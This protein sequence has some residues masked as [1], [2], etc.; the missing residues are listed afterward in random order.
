MVVLVG[1]NRF[2]EQLEGII[3]I[4]KILKV[5]LLTFERKR[6]SVFDV[7]TVIKH[8]ENTLPQLI[9]DSPSSNM[10]CLRRMYKFTGIYTVHV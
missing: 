6:S 9:V 7:Y 5:A 3:P 1:S 10:V 8:I 2:W 4:F